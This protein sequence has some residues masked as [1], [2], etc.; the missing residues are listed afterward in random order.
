MIIVVGCDEG[1]EMDAANQLRQAILKA[2][3]W[4]DND[5][6]ARIHLIPNVQCHGE[7]PRDID[8]VIL[9][10]VSPDRATFQPAVP[11][12]LLNGTPVDAD[13]VCVRS[14]CVV[15]EVKD[16]PP[17]SMRFVGAK[18]EVRYQNSSGTQQWHSASQQSERQKYSLRSYL[19]RNLPGLQVPHIT[20]L[21]WLRNATRD[22]LP[23]GTHNL[24]PSTLTWTGLLNAVAA[25]ACVWPEKTG[26]TLAATPPDSSF[27]F[28]QACDLLA[29]RLTP[30]ALDRRRMDR[31]ANAEIQDAWL[32][33]VGERQVI[34][35][36]RGGTGK[37]MIL[38][39]LAWRLQQRQRDRVLILTYNRALVADLRRLLT[40]MGLS[41]EVG[42]PC[43]EVQT[44]H[45][46]LFRFLTVIGLLDRDETDFLD[47]Y[48]AYK[49]DVLALLRDRALTREDVQEAA[50]KAPES[51]SWDYILVDEAQDWPQDE[52][53][54]LHLLY[55]SSS[56][57]I[58][59]GRDQLVRQNANCDWSRGS[60]PVPSRRFQLQRGL[61]MKANLARFA[62][63]LAED[64]GLA[65]WSIQE[66]TVAVGGKVIVI[67][68]DYA[69]AR[70]MHDAI[71]SN[72]R[73]AG[74]AP[75]DLLAC[76][77]PGMVIRDGPDRHAIATEL[78]A[79]WGYAVWDGASEDLR[80]AYPTSVE[81]LRVV[82]YD[83]CR[84]LE[85]WAAINLGIDDF[86][87]YKVAAWTKSSNAT[88][89]GVAD[90][91]LL[92]RRFAARWLMI[93]CSRAIDTLVLQ[94]RSRSSYLGRALHDTCGRC[95][96]FV[97]WA[98]V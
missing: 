24:L 29:R 34:F 35:E 94:I 50:R 10:V 96:D 11:L 3:P 44:V 91:V 62:N 71:V 13:S 15:L 12:Q 9:A 47:R 58:A 52:R 78:F 31:I 40:L 56:F 25:N 51:L 41:D 20:N 57:V 53:D 85:G 17:E 42:Q 26:V 43:V 45:A 2:W 68:G 87:D 92:G 80:R 83:S 97:E 60:E 84:G 75:V 93:P 36:G 72:A 59:D 66:N 22:V 48:D 27:S 89:A 65:A 67:E 5:P 54:I 76:V 16:H 74:N 38:L 64:L 70:S 81:Q 95:A 33:A 63:L 55:K 18:V 32:E 77:P 30:T 28:T 69:A 82:Q 6:T 14:V 1:P 88:D 39:G 98:R 79:A 90:D 61:R 23:R 8:L 21:I 86:F 4:A 46:F 49:A 19:A 73:S 37:T 7:T